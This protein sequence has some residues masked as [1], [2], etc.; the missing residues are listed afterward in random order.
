MKKQIDGNCNTNAS[1]FEV[2]ERKSGFLQIVSLLILPWMFQMRFKQKSNRD[3]SHWNSHSQHI[4]AAF[5]DEIK[6]MGRTNCKWGEKCRAKNRYEQLGYGERISCK[7]RAAK[8][9]R[10]KLLNPLGCGSD[11]LNT[12]HMA[13]IRGVLFRFSPLVCLHHIPLVNLIIYFAVA[14]IAPH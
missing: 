4:C 9:L 8:K 6:K 2:V 3:Q 10:S 1:P 13:R 12:R 5:T 14:A 7:K 11:P